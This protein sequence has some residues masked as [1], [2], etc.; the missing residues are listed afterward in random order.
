VLAFL[1]RANQNYCAEALPI[2]SEVRANFS[3]DP[4]LMEIVADSE[5]ICSRLAGSTG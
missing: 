3:D 1:S 4:I 5:G 2:L